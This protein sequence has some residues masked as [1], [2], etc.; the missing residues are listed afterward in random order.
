MRLA[1]F[2]ALLCALIGEALAVL[3]EIA[4]I[5]LVH[6]I[7]QGQAAAGAPRGTGIGWLAHYA[8]HAHDEVEDQFQGEQT[9]AGESSPTHELSRSEVLAVS[10]CNKCC[11]RRNSHPSS[12]STKRGSRFPA[13]SNLRM[14]FTCLTPRAH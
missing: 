2:G 12:A 5:E 4:T 11:S 7:G 1:I 9:A 3:S 6:S 14:S 8:Q 10:S 13:G